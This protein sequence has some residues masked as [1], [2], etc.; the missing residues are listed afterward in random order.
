MTVITDRRG[1]SPGPTK[2]PGTDRV[3]WSGK[4]LFYTGLLAATALLAFGTMSVMAVLPM[5]VPGYTSASITSGSMM[6]TFRIGDVVIAVDHGAAEIA[7][8]TIVIYENSDRDLVTH[9]VVSVKPDG[10]Y[11]TKGDMN[12]APDPDPIPAANIRGT[13]QW[14]V[15]FVGLLRIWAAQGQW[16]LL[17]ATIAAT[18]T[19]LWLSRFAF[20]H[21]R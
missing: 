18:A 12:G 3:H 17:I 2:D 20:Y 15:P 7:P 21:L 1:G 13:A 19:A 5:V 10:T 8:G 11:I 14:I 16:T 9:R 4:A 6:P